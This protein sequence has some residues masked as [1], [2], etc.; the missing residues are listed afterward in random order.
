MGE[1]KPLVWMHGEIKTP[2]FSADARIEAAAWKVGDADEF[3]GLSPE[4]VEFVEFK[5]ALAA[6]VKELR[7]SKG[8]TQVQVARALGSS[9]SRIAKLEAADASVSADFMLKSF[10]KLGAT[11]KDLPRGAVQRR[12]RRQETA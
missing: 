5:L 2:P 1:S 11:R 6:K 7:Q 3:L 9:Q 10:F 4:E 8:W 12:R